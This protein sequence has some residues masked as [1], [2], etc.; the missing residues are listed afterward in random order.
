MR[1]T[2]Q[3]DRY[4]TTAIANVTGEERT[5]IAWGA[6]LDDN[7][8]IFFPESVDISAVEAEVPSVK[9]IM[10]LNELRAERDILIAKTDWWASSDLTMTD[11]QINYR[12]ELR[13]ITNTYQS[14]DEVVWPT[15][16]V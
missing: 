3:N 15:P 1:V 5:N 12:Q 7:L 13:D 9:A 8:I 16:P 10:D 6:D 14:L 2:L 4:I 11:E